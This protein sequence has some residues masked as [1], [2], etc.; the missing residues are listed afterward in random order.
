[1]TGHHIP[2][3]MQLSMQIYSFNSY[4]VKVLPIVILNQKWLNNFY[5]TITET[6][7]ATAFGWIDYL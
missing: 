7:K 1:M 4:P 3:L 6:K 5:R 2:M